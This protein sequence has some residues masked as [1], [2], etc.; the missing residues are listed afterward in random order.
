MGQNKR[1]FLKLVSDYDTETMEEIR[2][3]I[4]NRWWRRILQNIHLRLLILRDKIKL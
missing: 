4:K 3:K 2:W 1:N